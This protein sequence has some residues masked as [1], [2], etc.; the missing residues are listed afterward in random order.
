MQRFLLQLLALLILSLHFN[1][2]DD[3][4][5]YSIASPD[6]QFSVVF[7]NRQMFTIQDLH[8][9]TVATTQDFPKLRHLAEFHSDKVSWSPDSQILAITGGGGHDLETFILV[10]RGRGFV[11]VT[12]PHITEG[13]DNAFIK[14]LKWLKGSRLV[15][16]IS[17]PHAGKARGYYYKG[18]ATVRVSISTPAC[19]VLYKQIV[20]HNDPIE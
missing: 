3:T 20:E 16:D 17:G 1:A 2:A 5:P 9:V 10:R 19:E 11:A 12:V 13:F 4:K 8:G 15:L 6:K 7:V 14:P 18:R